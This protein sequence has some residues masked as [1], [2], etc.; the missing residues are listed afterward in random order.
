MAIARED[1]VAQ[2]HP[3]FR[4]HQADATALHYADCLLLRGHLFLAYPADLGLSGKHFVG[5]W[6]IPGRKML[7]PA[8]A[9][10]RMGT[11]RSRPRFTWHIVEIG[12][13]HW[14][15]PQHRGAGGA[16]APTSVPVAAELNVRD[17]LRLLRP[18]RRRAGNALEH[19]VGQPVIDRLGR[20]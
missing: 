8:V 19:L 5:P 13:Q 15:G 16:L 1:F 2:R 3:A 7:T 12:R 11:L 10:K 20:I 4:D 6:R 14:L 17:S 18:A 9:M